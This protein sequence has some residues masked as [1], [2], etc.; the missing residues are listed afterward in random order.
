MMA[1][2][3][4]DGEYWQRVRIQ[5]QLGQNLR[6]K[7]QQ[8]AAIHGCKA[9]TSCKTSRRRRCVQGQRHGQHPWHCQPP[10]QEQHMAPAIQAISFCSRGAGIPLSQHWLL[11]SVCE[12]QLLL[13]VKSHKP[14][15]SAN[16]SVPPGYSTE[17][18]FREIS[19]HL[20]VSRFIC[21]L[22]YFFFLFKEDWNS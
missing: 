10:V 15:L 14:L 5:L 3:V 8:A 7:A 22:F 17:V 18:T 16:I 19:Q 4:V 6:G 2:D 13:T 1:R 11:L 21:M 20:S 12:Q 9:S